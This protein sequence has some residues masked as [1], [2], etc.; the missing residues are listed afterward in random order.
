MTMTTMAHGSARVRR[1]PLAAEHERIGATWISDRAH[2]PATYGSVERERGV[3]RAAAGLVD[4]GPL[5]KLSVTAP[6][7]VAGLAQVGLGGEVG[8]IAG[9]TLAGF[10]VD[11]W[12]LAPD[13]ALVVHPPA[14]P[15]DPAA[16]A[17][18][19]AALRSAGFA[20]VDLSSG[21][22]ALVVAGPTA[23]LVLGDC[24]PVDVHARVLP[25]RHVT[26]GPIAGIRTRVG[27]LDR[28]GVTSFTL[29]VARDLAVSLWATLLEVGE[30]HGLRPI[31]VDALPGRSA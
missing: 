17:P 6:D 1:S 27:R 12:F 20:P 16:P 29:L 4:L 31:G 23:R 15:A 5:V 14:D 21:I 3:V 24:F 28:G 2:W 13:E 22:A 25:D 30:V 8:A 11:A 10:S 19:V 18:A 9:G 26:S 7:V